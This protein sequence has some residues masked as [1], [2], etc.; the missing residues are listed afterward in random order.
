MEYDIIQGRD[1]SS[2]FKFS[3]SRSGGPGGQ[4]VN[5]VSTKVELRFNV[6]QSVL[7]LPEE[8]VV[9]LKKLENKINKDGELVLVSQSERSQLANKEKVVEKFYSLI[10]KALTPRKKR[11]PTKQTKA[12]KEK[13]LQTKKINSEKKSRR[14]SVDLT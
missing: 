12:S 11:K 3:T 4:N 6:A 14:K 10:V 9:I 5:K 8:K 7:L 13:R 2:E 1:F